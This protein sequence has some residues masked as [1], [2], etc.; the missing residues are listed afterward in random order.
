MHNE[1]EEQEL[2]N[3]NEPE[4]STESTE[5]TDNM[6]AE[7]TTDS[8]TTTDWEKKYQE[9]YDNYLRLFSEF[10]NFRK[11]TI[12]ERSDLLKNASSDVLKSLL[13]VLDDMERALS[14]SENSQDI[15]ALRTGIEL[16][17]QKFRNTLQEKGLSEM[18]TTGA[19]FD[20][21][22]HEAITHIPAPTDDM[23]GKIVDVVEKGYTLNDKIIR[24]PKVVVG[25]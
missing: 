6:T 12:K 20:P 17:Y 24:Y 25:N 22:L 10:D 11:R 21:E 13:P 7:T 4:G 18:D 16:I 2:T 8:E 15:N 23:K 19:V 14:A 5:N 9:T 3:H 1:K